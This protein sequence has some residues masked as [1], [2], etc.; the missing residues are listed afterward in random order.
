MLPILLLPLDLQYVVLIA[1]PSQQSVSY[2]LPQL[3]PLEMVAVF[4]S[5]HNNCFLVSLLALYHRLLYLRTDGGQSR[6]RK[7]W[8]IDLFVVPSLKMNQLSPNFEHKLPITYGILAANF[9]AICS[10]FLILWWT[11]VHGLKHSHH[12]SFNLRGLCTVFTSFVERNAVFFRVN[13]TPMMMYWQ[14]ICYISCI[15]A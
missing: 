12:Q 4:W 6:V 5:Q 7:L 11:P 1:F 10:A 15:T 14:K 13:L 8:S 2:E 3:L 9:F